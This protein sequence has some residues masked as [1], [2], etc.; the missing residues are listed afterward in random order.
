MGCIVAGLNP[1][2]IINKVLYSIMVSAPCSGGG[3]SS[4]LVVIPNNHE[5]ITLGEMPSTIKI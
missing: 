5:L 3:A 1:A 2:P 4:S